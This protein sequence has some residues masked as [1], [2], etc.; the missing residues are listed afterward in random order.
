MERNNCFLPCEQV[1]DMV[2]KGR[3]DPIFHEK[4][5]GFSVDRAGNIVVRLRKTRKQAKRQK[6]STAREQNVLADIATAA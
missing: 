1:R 5:L 2:G 3:I 6:V 4:A